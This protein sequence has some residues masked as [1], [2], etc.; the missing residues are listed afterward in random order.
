ML[1]KRKDFG[2][3]Q[4][5]MLGVRKLKKN[6]FGTLVAQTHCARNPIWQMGNSVES[7]CH[8]NPIDILKRLLVQPFSIS[9]DS[10]NYQ[11]K[12]RLFNTTKQDVTI[13]ADKSTLLVGNWKYGITIQLT[14]HSETLNSQ[15]FCQSSLTKYIL[16]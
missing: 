13:Y 14:R 16:V 15:G 4:R 7:F 3:M 9:A 11:Q 5:Q 10:Q 8:T 12:T 6:F 2:R 1:E